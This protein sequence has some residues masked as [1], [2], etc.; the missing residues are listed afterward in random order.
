MKCYD[1]DNE[2]K[3]KHHVVPKSKGGTKT[4]PLCEDCHSKVHGLNFDKMHHNYLVRLAMI[5]KCPEFYLGV[6]FA[7]VERPIEWSLH[8]PY[9]TYKLGHLQLFIEK[10]LGHTMTRQKI[11][12]KIMSMK[13]LDVDDILDAFDTIIKF[14]DRPYTRENW[15]HEWEGYV[16]DMPERFINS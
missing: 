2:A 16:E 13:E 12:R 9:N 11:S 3:H 15:K 1:C 14:D 7:V 5:R 10:E 6:F 8:E 4:I